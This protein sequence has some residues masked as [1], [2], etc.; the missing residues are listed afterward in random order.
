MKQIGLILL[1]INYILSFNLYSIIYPVK[2]TFTTIDKKW[3]WNNKLF[4]ENNKCSIYIGK[5]YYYNNI[6]LITENNKLIENP[7]C[8]NE[9]IVLSNYIC[10]NN[11]L[12]S[13]K[14]INKQVNVPNYYKINR[15]YYD[16]NKEYYRYEHFNLNRII[17][18]KNNNTQ[19]Y[20]KLPQNADILRTLILRPN[21]CGI[22]YTPY[23]PPQN[24]IKELFDKNNINSTNLTFTFNIWLTDNY[25]YNNSIRTGMHVSYDGINGNLKEFILKKD[26]LIDEHINTDN[27]LNLTELYKSKN[28]IVTNYTNKELENIIEFD[29]NTT[30]NY[31]ILKNNWVGNYR[32]HNLLNNT[33]ST[34]ISWSSEHKYYIPISNNDIINYYQLK[35]SDGIYINIPKNLNLFDDNETIYIEFASFFKNGSGIQRFLSWGTKKNGGFKTH[36]HDIWTKKY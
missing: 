30:I 12:K 23:I 8:Y 1:Y 7:I 31:I 28:K 10:N 20:N 6:D 34:Q 4:P 29:K 21:Y 33:P 2:N 13:S 24:I 11:K 18:L 17:K 27:K 9:N 5:W 32:I 26:N 19:I 16:N 22:T 14:I 25:I 3:N 35:F 36:C 15:R